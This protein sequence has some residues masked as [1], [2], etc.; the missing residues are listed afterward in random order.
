MAKAR[1]QK[2]SPTQGGRTNAALQLLQPIPDREPWTWAQKGTALGLGIVLLG[3]A[4]A[5][6]YSVD[7]GFD[8]PKRLLF[9]LGAWIAVI[10]TACASGRIE[11][12][13]RDP[14]WRYPVRALP[15]ILLVVAALLAV[16]SGLVAPGPS[17]WGDLRF[18][19]TGGLLIW[20]GM[21]IGKHHHVVKTVWVLALIAVL[22]NTLLS[23]L[24]HTDMP[25][26]VQVAR[27]GGRFDTG[28]LLGNEGLVSLAAAL[29]IPSL[30]AFAGKFKGLGRTSL[31]GAALLSVLVI[32][33]NQQL[34]SLIAAAAGGSVWAVLR[35]R[36][37][38]IARL[39]PLFC[40]I[41]LVVG[42]VP[43]LRQPVLARI[44]M[45]TIASAQI[46]TT[47][48]LGAV[49]ASVAMI[50]E[51]PWLGHG[52]GSY[53]RDSQRF[54]VRA[55]E[56]WRTRLEMPPNANAFVYAHQDY[57]QWG[58]EFGL[59]SLLLG[60]AGLFAVLWRCALAAWRN[61]DP[62]TLAVVSTLCAGAVM[63]LAWFPIHVPILA[64]LLALAFGR[65]VVLGEARS[66]GETP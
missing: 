50:N 35:W 16:V 22:A 60:L 28:G 66:L 17:D 27:L 25:S 62:E 41:A 54:R 39:T 31:I 15:R 37:V 57:L 21:R 43:S 9:L 46:K 44:G 24:Q 19:A 56:A 47:Y 4:F 61:A 20:M 52:P 58:A 53:A 40:V 42:L 65:A 11:G 10:A 30:L 63:A 55:A 23:L 7:Q 6:D 38:W 64:A 32:V 26:P 3:S 45:Q 49:A 18:I 34:T 33:L 1:K 29:S 14:F 48:R 12:A 2:P 36:L 51:R 8:A 13:L 59:P 5:L